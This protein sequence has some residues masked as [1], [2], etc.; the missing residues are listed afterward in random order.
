MNKQA[1]DWEKTLWTRLA[2]D[3][4]PAYKQQSYKSVE[5]DGPIS[6]EG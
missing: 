1:T 6:K 3:L 5:A 4:Y 2:K